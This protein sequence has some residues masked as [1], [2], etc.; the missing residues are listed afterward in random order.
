[1]ASGAGALWVS[2]TPDPFSSSPTPDTSQAELLKV[3]LQSSQIL[4]KK[5]PTGW[6]F[7][8]F[9]AD[10]DGVWLY[11]AEGALLKIRVK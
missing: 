7:Q 4:G 6:R 1:M 2:T 5:I 11:D 8:V 9:H 10:D 3:D